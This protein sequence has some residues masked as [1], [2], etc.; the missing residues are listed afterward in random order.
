MK[1][2]ENFIQTLIILSIIAFALETESSLQENIRHS[3]IILKSL[4]S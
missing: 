2:A 4:Q 1:I 3:L